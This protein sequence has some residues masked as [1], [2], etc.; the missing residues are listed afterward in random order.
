M[1]ELN[2]NRSHTALSPSPFPNEIHS[3]LVIGGYDPSLNTSEI[4]TENGWEN[5]LPELPVTVFDT[6]SVLLNSTTVMVIGGSQ[7]EVP[8]RKTFLLN[9]KVSR[10]DSSQN[11]RNAEGFG[12]IEE[13]WIEGPE[14]MTERLAALSF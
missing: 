11:P 2:E 7:N 8:S 5:L 12:R 14:L 1:E 4:L 9:T 10:D 13:S 6:C 3:V